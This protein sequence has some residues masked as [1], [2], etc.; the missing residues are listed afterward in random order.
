MGRAGLI[1]CCLSLAAGVALAAPPAD[2]G[3]DAQ[4][5]AGKK[6]YD[7][8]CSQCHGDKGDGQGIATP[9]LLPKP[10]DFTAGKFK[11]RT[12]P[13]GALPTTQDLKSII[14]AGMPYTAMPAW[15]QFNDQQ[16]TAL[17]YTVKSFAAD[18][19]KPDRQPEPI[20]IPSPPSS[21]KESIEKGQKLYGELGCA[22]CHGE[23]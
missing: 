11:I 13:S 22:R 7:V 9:F 6:L 19:A 20:Q 10:R 3:S 5:A 8:N 15:P 16:L 12:T 17:A 1:A 18:F 14:R 23:V 2:V 21:S 4:R